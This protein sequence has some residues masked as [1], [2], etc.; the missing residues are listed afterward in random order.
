M[1][2][3]LYCQ[4]SYNIYIIILGFHM[5]KC[6]QL[7]QAEAVT[8]T[9]ILRPLTVSILADCL[10][11]VY[12]ALECGLIDLIIKYNTVAKVILFNLSHLGHQQ[13]AVSFFTVRC[14]DP[15]WEDVASARLWYEPLMLL[16]ELAH[17]GS[18]VSSPILQF[19]VL[20]FRLF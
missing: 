14:A 11:V 17:S 3:V 5:S 20:F 18:L 4:Y 16:K 7:R 9:C 15:T 1:Q 12:S 6:F 19:C 2:L 10:L 13:V 8:S